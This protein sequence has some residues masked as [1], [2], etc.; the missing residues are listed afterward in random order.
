MNIKKDVA[1]SDSGFV[2]NPTTGESYSV[3][4]IG[5]NIIRLMKEGKSFKE[6]TEQIVANYHA[7]PTTIDKDLYDFMEMLNHYSLMD[8]NGQA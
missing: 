3:N 4:P 7:E 5:M 1:V 6:I 8:D 2:F